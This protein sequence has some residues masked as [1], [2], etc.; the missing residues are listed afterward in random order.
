MINC[1]KKYRP[2][3]G[4]FELLL[5]LFCSVHDFFIRTVLHS[6]VFEFGE[7]PQLRI[8]NRAALFSV[9]TGMGNFKLHPRH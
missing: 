6:Y 8:L 9:L 7:G 2:I 1:I 5:P 3:S 4:E